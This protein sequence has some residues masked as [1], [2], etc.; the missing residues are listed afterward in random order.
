MIMDAADVATVS[1]MTV[2]MTDMTSIM[3]LDM[4]TGVMTGVMTDAIVD[5]VVTGADTI[6][7]TTGVRKHEWSCRSSDSSQ[8]TGDSFL[9]GYFWSLYNRAYLQF[10]FVNTF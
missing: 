6:A 4:M 1:L 10:L 9:V 8:F 5:V 7:M 2:T 3:T